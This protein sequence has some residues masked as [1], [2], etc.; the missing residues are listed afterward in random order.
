MLNESRMC[1]VVC[2]VGGRMGGLLVFGVWCLKSATNEISTYNVDNNRQ[3]AMKEITER[4]TEM[5]LL[6]FFA[7]LLLLF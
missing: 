1:G 3:S 2:E 6:L 4:H 5:L 7:L